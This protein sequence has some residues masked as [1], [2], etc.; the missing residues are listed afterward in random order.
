MEYFGNMDY[1]AILIAFLTTDSTVCFECFQKFDKNQCTDF[2]LPCLFLFRF[3]FSYIPNYFLLPLFQW[4][5]SRGATSDLILYVTLI[6]FISLCINFQ[7]LREKIAA[8][9]VLNENLYS[10]LQVGKETSQHYQ[11]TKLYYRRVSY[12]I[13]MRKRVCL[14]SP[15]LFICA[16][17][18]RYELD[19][20]EF[21]RDVSLI[22]WNV[23]ILQNIYPYRLLIQN[24]HNFHY[25]TYKQMQYKDIW[26]IYEINTYIVYYISL[27]P[28]EPY[29]KEM[30][31]SGQHFPR[32]MPC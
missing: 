24:S 20:V 3:S 21:E 6:W 11:P 8:F 26:N 31:R 5:I 19:G 27:I 7:V 25:I 13:L 29:E 18:D 28:Q 9:N 1:I 10:G 12:S 15:V 4:V 30:E 23:F 14:L 16:V 17:L 32:S 2:T 22:L